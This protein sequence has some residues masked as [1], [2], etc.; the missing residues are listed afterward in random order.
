[1]IEPDSSL[2]IAPGMI[3]QVA[4]LLEA[5]ARKPGNVHRFLDFDDSSYLDFALSAAAIVEPLNRASTQEVGTTILQAV[6]ATR[7]VV[8]TNTNLGMIL[9]LA[10][11][12]T[13]P[14]G[15]PLRAGLA[16][17]LDRTTVA[18]SIDVYK[19]IR[20]A[21]PGGLG[22]SEQG[23]DVGDEP[24]VTLVDAMRLA[25]DR[26]LVARQYA[27]GYADV[28][29]RFVPALERGLTRWGES[30]ETAMVAAFLETLV[31]RPD[32]F[33][34]PEAR[35]GRRDRGIEASGRGPRK[36]LARRS[37]E[38]SGSGQVRRLAPGRW[39][40]PEPRRVG[41]PRRERL[42][43]R[44]SNWDN[45]LADRNPLV[46]ETI[47]VESSPRLTPGPEP[48]RLKER[49]PCPVLALTRLE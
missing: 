26:D 9:L 47:R 7:R 2:I 4:C 49:P 41:R 15:Q 48:P 24:T 25:S 14:A 33:D 1:M 43:C 11:L 40:R 13:V 18:D 6:E 22:Q 35:A 45:P 3:A 32:T 31:D 34:R 46:L 42:V 23:Q 28:F 36:G 21:N 19:A 20:L 17:V 30:L 37:Q 27:S 16:S 12:A 39:A 29:D 8:G 5:T 44:P 38:C 10:P